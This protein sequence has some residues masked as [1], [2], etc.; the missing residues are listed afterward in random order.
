MQQTA[1]TR[2]HLDFRN[3]KRTFYLE[4]DKSVD[5]RD[6]F[7]SL[8]KG[9]KKLR[10]VLNSVKAST[11]NNNKKTVCPTKKF[12][13]IGGVDYPGTEIANQINCRWSK[14]YYSSDMRTFLFKLSHN[15]LS[16]SH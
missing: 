9:S 12:S 13:E 11:G 7:Q 16:A 4:G 5:F 2:E 10:M 3:A 15:T 14:N 1:Q 6:F 8:K